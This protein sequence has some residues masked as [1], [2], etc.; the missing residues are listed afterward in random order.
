MLQSS[1]SDQGSSPRLHECLE[2]HEKMMRQR[3]GDGKNCTST[4]WEILGSSI[5]GVSHSD[6]CALRV[7][8]SDSRWGKYSLRKL[9]MIWVREPWSEFVSSHLPTWTFWS[10]FVWSSLLPPILIWG[11]SPVSCFKLSRVLK[12]NWFLSVVPTQSVQRSCSMEKD[13]R[14]CE[15]GSVVEGTPEME[16]SRQDARCPINRTVMTRYRDVDIMGKYGWLFAPSWTLRYI[17]DGNLS[18]KIHVSANRTSH[19]YYL[20]H[21]LPKRTSIRVEFVLKNDTRTKGEIS[22]YRCM[23]GLSRGVR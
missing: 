21:E 8:R 7:R 6:I 3:R 5:V 23:N 1:C 20:I 13:I 15:T 19:Q 22:S 18:K 17:A 2:H 4:W 9:N 16:T 11:G 14:D 10:K 12:K